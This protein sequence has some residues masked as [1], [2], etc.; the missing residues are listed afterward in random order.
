M[1]AG[2]VDHR[3]EVPGSEEHLDTRVGCRSFHSP[4]HWWGQRGELGPPS[5]VLALHFHS[6]S[7]QVSSL[8]P[9][10]AKGRWMN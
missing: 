10:L 9:K 1:E 8:L 5:L 6:H 7:I 3:D 2:A 4:Q